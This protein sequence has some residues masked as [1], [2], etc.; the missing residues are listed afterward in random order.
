ME[1]LESLSE[2]TQR[3]SEGDETLV[4]V[5]YSRSVL[6][7]Y[8]ARSGTKAMKVNCSAQGKCICGGS[9]STESEVLLFG[10]PMHCNKWHVDLRMNTRFL[11][12]TVRDRWP[13]VKSGN[14]LSCGLS[15]IPH[16]LLYLL[17]PSWTRREHGQ[18]AGKFSSY[19]VAGGFVDWIVYGYCLGFRESFTLGPFMQFPWSEPCNSTV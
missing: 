3:V 7:N 12:S 14:P 4:Q 1:R 6:L 8:T 16:L 10:C 13:F 17:T 2:A 19:W 5:V 15:N 9:S 18:L 11:T